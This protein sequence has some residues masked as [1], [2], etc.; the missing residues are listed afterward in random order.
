MSNYIPFLQINW[1]FGGLCK[2]GVFAN[3]SQCI[4]GVNPIMEK[5]TPLHLESR[6]SVE[7]RNYPKWIKRWPPQVEKYGTAPSCR[8]SGA[9]VKCD[10]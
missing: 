9:E 7:E 6:V 4:V 8:N 3:L 5:A 1:L 10:L 2:S